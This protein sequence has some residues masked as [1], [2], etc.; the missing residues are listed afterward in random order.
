VLKKASDPFVILL[1]RRRPA[2]GNSIAIKQPQTIII[3]D[4]RV[5]RVQ[6][7]EIRVQKRRII[8]VQK[9]IIRVQRKRIISVQKEEIRCSKKK[10]N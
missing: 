9:R 1:V 6:K 3:R 5:I 4:I 2:C 7:R 8:R 10:N